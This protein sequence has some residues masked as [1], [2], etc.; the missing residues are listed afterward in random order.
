MKGGD[1]V[2]WFFSAVVFLSKYFEAD[3][4]FVMEA[5]NYETLS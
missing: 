3:K 5:E 2:S 1:W 4:I